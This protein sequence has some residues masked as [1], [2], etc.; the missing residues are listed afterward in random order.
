MPIVPQVQASWK[1]AISFKARGETICA[2]WFYG[3]T[4]GMKTINKTHSV[5]VGYFFTAGLLGLGVLYDLWT[6]NGQVSGLNRWE[7]RGEGR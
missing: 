1:L 6:L 2:P 5:L 7:L 4:D 3:Y